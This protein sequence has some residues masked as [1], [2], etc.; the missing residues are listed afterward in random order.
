MYLQLL[1]Q[2]FQPSYCSI[3][4][5]SPWENIWT[6]HF[7]SVSNKSQ[8]R[9]LLFFKQSDVLPWAYLNSSQVQKQTVTQ[10][11]EFDDPFLSLGSSRCLFVLTCRF[12]STQLKV[13]VSP[14]VALLYLFDLSKAQTPALAT[15]VLAQQLWQLVQRLSWGMRPDIATTN[16]SILCFSWVTVILMIAN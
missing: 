2:L 9:H 15:L 1:L 7:D 12:S 4:V 10:Q 5:L 13:V 3:D 8:Q 6:K 14:F 11:T 16:F